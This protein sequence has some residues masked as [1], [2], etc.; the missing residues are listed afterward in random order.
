MSN[1]KLV[2][3]D[4]ANVSYEIPAETI[5]EGYEKAI[6]LLGWSLLEEK[7]ENEDQLELDIDFK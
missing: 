6:N 1:Y 7:R 3:S 5:E 4:D 2:M